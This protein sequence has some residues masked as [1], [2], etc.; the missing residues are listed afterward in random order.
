MSKKIIF[1]SKAAVRAMDATQEFLRQQQ[2]QVPEKFIVAGESKVVQCSVI[3]MSISEI[4]HF[5]FSA[6]M[7]K[8]V[9]LFRISRILCLSNSMAYSRR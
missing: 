7:D 4:F 6:W 9:L 3:D 2:V 5:F 1:V 8:Y